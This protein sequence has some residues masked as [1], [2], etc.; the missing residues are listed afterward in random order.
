MGKKIILSNESLKYTSYELV[1]M[2]K[3]EIK[4][5]E[6][7]NKFAYLNDI[8]VNLLKQILMYPKILSFD[9]YK[10]IGKIVNKSIK[11][12]TEIEV[13]K[14]E[15]DF[16]GNPDECD[17]IEEFLLFSNNLFEEIIINLKIRGK[18]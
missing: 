16:R 13:H 12:L 9:M 4:K 3:N 1:N 11:E 5:Y 7:L 14:I 15:P 17:N 6:D 10:I 2:V 8:D 18:V